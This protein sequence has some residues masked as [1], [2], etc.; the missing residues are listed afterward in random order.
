MYHPTKALVLSAVKYG[1]NSRVLRCF[2]REFGLQAYMVNSISRKKGVVNAAMILPLSQLELVVT[3][4][5]KG[6]LER[7]KEARIGLPYRSLHTDPLRNAVALFLAELLS[8]ALREA[9]ADQAKFDF[10]AH[11]CAALDGLAYVPPHFHLSFMLELMK[12]LG[13]YPDQN[14]ANT[15]PYFDMVEGYFTQFKPLHP[16]YMDEPTTAALRA[17]LQRGLDVKIPKAL[18][19][20]L[21]HQLLQYY[22]IHLAEFGELKSVEVLTDL[23]SD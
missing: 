14:K 7:I 10:I 8:R 15:A 6:T 21:L 11:E 17:V 12:H 13:F 1:E 5:G 23:F 20:Q 22:R 4:R 16:Y 19:K 2:T 3:H 18:R 9:G